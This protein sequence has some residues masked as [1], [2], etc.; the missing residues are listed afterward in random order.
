MATNRKPVEFKPWPQVVSEELDRIRDGLDTIVMRLVDDHLTVEAKLA[1]Q[2]Q[3]TELEKDFLHLV[4]ELH[5]PPLRPLV[6]APTIVKL[7]AP[8]DEARLM[9]ARAAAVESFRIQAECA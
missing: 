6:H 7:A 4:G 8:R 3:R 2:R 1:L 5:K 9:R